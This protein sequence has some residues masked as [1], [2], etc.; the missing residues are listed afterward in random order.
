MTKDLKRFIAA[1]ER[2]YPVALAEIRAG[3]KRSHWMWYIFPQLEGL[4]HSPMAQRYAISGAEEAAAYLA[5]D[6]LGPRLVEISRALM[7]LAGSDATAVMGTPDDLKLWSCMTLFSM[8]PGADKVFSEV[9]GKY[10]GGRRDER[11]VEM[12]RH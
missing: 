6:V 7:G 3:R 11:T 10:Y 5:D 4:G 8:V 2:D 9:L 1:Q 12:L